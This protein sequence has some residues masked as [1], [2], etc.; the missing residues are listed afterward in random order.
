[1]GKVLGSELKSFRENRQMTTHLSSAYKINAQLSA[2]HLK[3]G[4][5]G[6][7]LP[8][9]VHCLEKTLDQ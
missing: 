4:E 5:Q 6:K 1:M 8:P 3:I 7:K 2:V 9:L